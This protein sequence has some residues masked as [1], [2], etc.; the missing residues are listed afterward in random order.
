MA[1]A[2]PADNATHAA[3]ILLAERFHPAAPSAGTTG[4]D[5]EGPG[6]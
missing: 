6:H 2:A 5:G 1:R 3:E 4:D